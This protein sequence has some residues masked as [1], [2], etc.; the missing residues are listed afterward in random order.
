MK[1]HLLLVTLLFCVHVKAQNFEW[2][3]SFGGT[4][5]DIG[6]S[7]ITDS[8]GN[9]FSTG[10]FRDIVDFDPGFG[11]YSLTSLGGSDIFITKLDSNGDFVWAKQ[12]GGSGEDAG[13]GI[14]LDN[15]GNIFISGYFS[16]TTDFDPSI[17][18]STLMS[19][20]STDLFVSKYDNQGNLIWAKNAGANSHD[21]A[22]AIAIDQLGNVY[23]TGSFFGTVDFNPGP[24][25]NNLI[26]SSLSYNAFILKLDSNGNYVWAKSISGNPCNS[27]GYSIKRDLSNNIYVVGYFS[28][29]TDFDPNTS[30]YW[31]NSIGTN[32]AFI[33]KVDSSGSFLWA[34]NIGSPSQSCIGSA[35]TLDIDKNIFITGDFAGTPDFN[36]GAGT[37]TISSNGQKDAYVLKLDSSGNFNWVK[38]I[39]GSGDD[40]GFD[41]K[42]DQSKNI[43]LM[44]DFSST[45]DFNPGAGINT[46]TSAGILDVF[47]L[48]LDS[49]A[50]FVYSKNFGGSNIDA[51]YS[52]CLDNLGNIYITGYFN[53]L[54]EY[55]PGSGN[56]LLTSN[57]LGDVFILKLNTSEITQL[58]MYSLLQSINIYPNPNNGNFIIV[59]KEK[60]NLNLINNLGQKIQTI[61]L[62]NSNE[63][64]ENIKV[65]TS[66]MY[67]ITGQTS[68]ESIK[69]KIIVTK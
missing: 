48:K 64:Q 60:M 25:I 55:S 62:N 61:E 39:G 2:A 68:Q 27:Q 58:N 37:Y 47:I 19:I 1:N 46:M 6:Y 53:G 9:L 35:L 20:G 67:F 33:L 18:T 15:S 24:A 63:F 3:K 50:N 28:G 57:G 4:G 22:L 10:F 12:I 54:A 45:V 8:Q 49:L 23:T 14:T 26:A 51:G 36:S 52:L 59:A 40:Y 69:Q 56:T 21:E 17:A 29:N 32:D 42:I 13:H 5:N 31:I 16:A 44:G 34:N 38:R 41:I 66:G 30:T 65:S 43:F 7:S 11:N